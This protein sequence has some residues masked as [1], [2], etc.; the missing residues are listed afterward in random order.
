MVIVVPAFAHGDKCQP[1]V[2]AAVVLGG[3][4]AATKK[5]GERIDGTGAVKQD[6]GGNKK[7]PYEHL[8]TAG[9]RLGKAAAAI[10]PQGVHRH[11]QQNGHDGVE[12][13]KKAQFG[14][15]GQV[16]HIV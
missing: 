1:D 14:K 10:L 9:P 15:T 4:A 12:A 3:K 2:I 6:D 7:T 11:C 5:V 8:P 16:A 13:V